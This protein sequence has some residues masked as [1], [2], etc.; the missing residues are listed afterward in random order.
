VGNFKHS[1]PYKFFKIVFGRLRIL[2]PLFSSF[3]I[4]NNI[5]SPIF[6]IGSGR[7]G[8]TLMRRFINNHSEIFI[9]P[10]TYVLGSVIEKFKTYKGASWEDIVSIVYSKFELHPEFETFRLGSLS[11]LKQRANQLSDNDR[12]LD[13][14]LNLFYTFYAEQKG[15]NKVRWGDKT[16]L[17]AF[18]LSFINQVF[19]DAKYI[20]IIR[21]P[22]DSIH[23]YVKAGIYGTY[24]KSAKRWA[25]SVDLCRKFGSNKKKSYYEIYYEDLV[26]DPKKEL[27]NL[28]N[29]LS[30]PFEMEMMDELNSSLGDVDMRV[31]HKN[32]K[33]KV[34]TS[35]IG[36]G[37]REIPENNQQSI[38]R[39]LS[40]Y[41]SL[42]VKSVLK[43]YCD[44]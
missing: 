33:H 41:N 2:F 15:I 6:I 17:N 43:K 9:P 12:S 21:N 28:C 30:I 29:F 8:N 23:S 10:E 36:K 40:N 18:A 13:N 11:N 34:V 32:V 26:S 20:H 27:V 37:I 24:E 3:K 31:H 5:Y 25:T 39:I 7:S 14:L 4:T 42:R 35:Y 22:F 1:N 16:P 44:I 19:P 38:I